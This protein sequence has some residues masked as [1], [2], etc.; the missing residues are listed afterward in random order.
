MKITPKINKEEILNSLHKVL[1]E[2]IGKEFN[3]YFLERVT[4]HS[5]H[6]GCNENLL[7]GVQ[8]SLQAYEDAYVLINDALDRHILN[9]GS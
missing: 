2:Q 6:E 5:N 7:K 9:G 8:G 4:Y 1:V 3:A